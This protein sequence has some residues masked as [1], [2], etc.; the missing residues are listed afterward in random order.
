M[1][2]KKEMIEMMSQAVEDI[3][4]YIKF[5]RSF[6][7]GSNQEITEIARNAVTNLTKRKE[8]FICHKTYWENS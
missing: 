3:D 6:S 8:E 2:I 7:R 5:F 1:N 4:S